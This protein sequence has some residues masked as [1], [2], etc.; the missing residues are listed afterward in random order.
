MFTELSRSEV[1]KTLKDKMKI[2][3]S[4]LESI[5]SE[6]IKDV[7]YE[8]G[9]MI[10]DSK[11]EDGILKDIP[12]IGTLINLN[13]GRLSIQDRI[14]SKKILHFL[15]R[16]KE[17]EDEKRIKMIDKIEK[18]EPDRIK[19]GEKV[20]YLLDKAD[21]HVKAEMIGV[22]F[23][24]M[25]RDKLNYEGFKR[26]S[27]IINKAF[28]DDLLWFIESDDIIVSTEDSSELISAGLFDLPY[29]LKLVNNRFTGEIE[30][31]EP[32]VD[33]NIRDQDKCTINYFAEK[34]RI[35]LKGKFN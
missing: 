22:L 28:L 8:F 16:L 24:D 29:Q 26:C 9:E 31:Q 6:G 32:F 13:K 7:S 11:L 4:L 35:S 19:V 23:T 17:V 12:V 1:D 3:E 14:F 30:D 20:L 10:I 34:L 2:R 25:I 33:Y 15:Y 18:S 21:D 27:D 5:K